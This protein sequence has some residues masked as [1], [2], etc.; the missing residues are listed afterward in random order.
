LIGSGGG[1]VLVPVLLMVMPAQDPARLTAL[2]RHPPFQRREMKK[3][4][5]A[6]CL[7]SRTF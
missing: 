7:R 2:L 1:S 5:I 4:L 6:S 3:S